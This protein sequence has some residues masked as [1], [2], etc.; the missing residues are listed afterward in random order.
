[1]HDQE[2]QSL[3]SKA[4]D[5]L[6]IEY[7]QIN[8]LNADPKNPRKISETELSKLEK[9]IRKHGF[10]SP[11]IARRSDRTI[12]AGHQ[13]AKAAARI[14]L[15][16]IPVVF[17]DTDEVSSKLLSV[18]LNKISGED[19]P[20]I[21]REMF[22][23]LEANQPELDLTI[24]GFDQDEI[25]KFL[26]SAKLKEKRDQ[27][28]IFDIEK[29]LDSNRKT[30]LTRIGDIF[31]LAEHRI[32]CGDARN[33]EHLDNVMKGE[34]A[35]LMF[36]DPPYNA[37][38]TQSSTKQSAGSRAIINDNLP[39]GEWKEFVDGWVPNCVSRVNGAMYIC[40][41]IK[42]LAVVGMALENHDAHWSD[43]LIWVKDRFVLGRSDYQRSFEPI[44]Y[45]WPAGAKRH[46]SGGRA[47]SD[48]WRID[49]PSDSPLHPTMKPLELIERALENSSEVGDTILDPFLGSGS[50]L[51][52]AER[53]GR[54]LRGVEISPHYVDVAVARWEA[55]SGEKAKKI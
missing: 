7:V 14:G 55:F 40:P 33:S 34:T 32:I 22:A 8:T 52:A 18:A 30:S 31:E 11:V 38:F 25:D 17:V 19:D 28:E 12:I 47:Q 3:S 23:E 51:I 37:N 2:S 21:L 42:E 24:S 46:W 53:T 27:V 49:R 35:R 43:T 36:A 1:M 16:T 48:V 26:N 39:K 9:A 20:D 4:A 45:G 50:S 44:W 13:R 15:K 10:V 5:E 29:A 6:Q 41:G 54:K